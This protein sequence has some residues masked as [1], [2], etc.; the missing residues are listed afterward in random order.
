M[1]QMTWFNVASN[2]VRI[3]GTATVT[4][5]ESSIT[6]KKQAHNAANPTHGRSRAIT[7]DQRLSW[8]WNIR[9]TL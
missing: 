3:A 2:P 1:T 5:V 6:R 7:A 8:R 9:W 4:I